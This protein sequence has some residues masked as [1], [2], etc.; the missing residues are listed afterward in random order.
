M[1]EKDKI[2]AEQ[3]QIG[4]DEAVQ[5]DTEAAETPV[6][7]EFLDRRQAAMKD[8]RQPGFPP[9]EETTETAT[10]E[11]LPNEPETDCEPPPGDT[12]R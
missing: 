4:P 11:S 6:S 3:A 5:A 1:A 10:A 12:S 7:Q 8:W 2:Q 9:L